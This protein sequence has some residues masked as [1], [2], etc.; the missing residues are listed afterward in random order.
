[1]HIRHVEWLKGAGF[2]HVG[3]HTVTLPR[4]QRSVHFERAARE[5]KAGISHEATCGNM[6]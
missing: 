2:N 4:R 1:M 5:Q 6:H 3:R